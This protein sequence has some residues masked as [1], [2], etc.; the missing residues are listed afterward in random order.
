LVV[1]NGSFFLSFAHP[2]IGIPS[3][4]HVFLIQYRR[5]ALRWAG[6]VFLIV[7]LSAAHSGIGIPSFW[8]RFLSRRRRW[9]SLRVWMSVPSSRFLSAAHSGIGIPSFWQRFLSRRRR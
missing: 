9:I 3:A 6:E 5:T 8:Q 4:M 1:I 2:G 7:F